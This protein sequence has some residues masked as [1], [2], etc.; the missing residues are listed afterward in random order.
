MPFRSADDAHAVL[1]Y[2]PE[3]GLANRCQVNK[4]HGTSCRFGNIRDV[5]AGQPSW[6]RRTDSQVHVA[7]TVRSA[8]GNRTKN[9]GQ[10]D[11]RMLS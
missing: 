3:Q 4:I 11:V 1:K 5:S 2:L 7:I 8:S 6:L 10:P 9:V